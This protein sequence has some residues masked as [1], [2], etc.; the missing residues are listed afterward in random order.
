MNI[1]KTLF[2]FVD[3]VSEHAVSVLDLSHIVD[4]LC[5]SAVSVAANRV[6]VELGVSLPKH[7]CLV[8]G[9]AEVWVL[10]VVVC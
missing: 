4:G 5:S 9:V 10:V 8:V 2:L 6:V 7:G 1:V 3:I